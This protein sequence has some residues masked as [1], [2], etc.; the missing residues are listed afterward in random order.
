MTDNE[1][2]V[3]FRSASHS[4]KDVSSSVY[5]GLE[6]IPTHLKRSMKHGM[7]ERN[8]ASTSSVDSLD[9]VLKKG[10]YET[11]MEKEIMEQAE[12]IHQSMLGRVDFKNLSVDL[13]GIENY[14]DEINRCRRIICIGAASSYHVAVGTRQTMEELLEIPV[15]VELASDFLDREVPVFRD[16]VCILISQSGE[17]SS[18]LSA[19]MYCKQR[20]ALVLGITN[21]ENSRLSD[22]THC[23]IN[24]NAGIELGVTS[25]KTYICQFVSLVMFAVFLAGDKRS[26]YDRV[27]SIIKEMELLPQKIKK[28]LSLNTNIKALAK[29]LHNK[30]SFIL[31]GR[32]YHQATSFEGSLKL[33]EIVNV[34]SEGIHSGELKHGPLALIDDQ[35]PI[36]MIVMKDGIYDKC[37]NAVQQ[38]TARGGKP[39]VICEEGDEVVSKFAHTTICIPKTID[40]LSGILAVIP[41]QLLALHLAILH[42]KSVDTPLHIQ[43]TVIEDHYSH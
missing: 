36:I 16:D 23:G 38:V 41:L 6:V 12:A 40:C 10:P 1:N 42:G 28:V 24:I 31:L 13:R 14:R 32:G 17:T 29:S 15:F 27:C 4:W 7:K 3:T 19:C 11:Y 5:D 34:H 8:S 20:D 18:V 30:K 35:M 37:M 9:G 21:E 2:N 43:K 22:E 25:T 39:I 26:K 33:K